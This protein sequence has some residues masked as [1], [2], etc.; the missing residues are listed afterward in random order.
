[1][2]DAIVLLEG[3]VERSSDGGTTW[4]DIPEAKGIAIPTVEKEYKD[5]TSLASGGFREY[6]PGLKDA[7]V[8]TVPCNYTPDGYEAMLADEAT[9]D[10]IMYRATLDPAPSQS[11][12]DVF[13][14]AGFPTPKVD[15]PSV[16]DEVMMNLEIRT[17]GTV[18]WTKGAAAV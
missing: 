5:V 7:G 18:T 4:T 14:F 3:T 1:M 10:V 16:G 12:G 17:S 15:N 6:K 11:A 8:I 2:S 9:G 13:T